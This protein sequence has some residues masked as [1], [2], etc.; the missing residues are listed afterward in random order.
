MNMTGVVG[1]APPC[2]HCGDTWDD[3]IEFRTGRRLRPQAGDFGMC[4]EC[5][6][7]FGYE[8][9]AIGLIR[10]LVSDADKKRM[11]RQ[12]AKLE[13]IKAIKELLTKS[14]AKQLTYVEYELLKRTATEEEWGEVCDRIKSARDGAYP[15]EWFMRIVASGFMA[16]Q[17]AKWKEKV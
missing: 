13:E 12:P 2:P 4:C 10:V 9:C 14:K 1:D 6:G 11:A 17:V 3:T 8:P 15:T 5:L 7:V 16:K